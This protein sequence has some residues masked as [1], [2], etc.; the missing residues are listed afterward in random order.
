MLVDFQQGTML[1]NFQDEYGHLFAMF[2]ETVTDGLQSSI[3]PKIRPKAFHSTSQKRTLPLYARSLT[4]ELLRLPIE[5]GM[6]I[7]CLAVTA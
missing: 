7:W 4:K 3:T 2:K 6:E 1:R 5:N